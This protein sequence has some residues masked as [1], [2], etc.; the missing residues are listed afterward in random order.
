MS[1][2][3]H[4]LLTL[5]VFIV[6]FTLLHVLLLTCEPNTTVNHELSITWCACVRIN[7][8]YYPIYTSCSSRKCRYLSA[9]VRQSVDRKCAFRQNK[10]SSI[11]VGINFGH[12]TY[13]YANHIAKTNLPQLLTL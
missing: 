9:F 6:C 12:I 1:S 8:T 5:M 11:S 13:N 3:V 7:T 2:A 4:K 10:M